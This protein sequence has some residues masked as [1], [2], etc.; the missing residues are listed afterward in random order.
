MSN[1]ELSKASPVT[2]PSDAVKPS[3]TMPET[4]NW[5]GKVIKAIKS[6]VFWMSAALILLGA[7]AQR[8]MFA[9][10]TN[11]PDDMPAGTYGFSVSP[12]IQYCYYNE[13]TQPLKSFDPPVNDNSDI[14]AE[15]TY[16][17]S[18]SPSIQYCFNST[19]TQPLKFE[20]LCPPGTNGISYFPKF[21]ECLN[22]T[23]TAPLEIGGICEKPFQQKL[24]RELVD[25]Q[26]SR[27]PYSSTS[28]LNIIAEKPKAPQKP[29]KPVRIKFL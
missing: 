4:T 23:L 20:P 15:G 27:M 1:V 26:L 22:S 21:Q 10:V 13:F 7:A 19:L 3:K 8:G 16:G 11:V 29:V 24:D 14:F 2:T 28:N 17:F 18:V 6:P 5:Q 25:L 12:T 9:P